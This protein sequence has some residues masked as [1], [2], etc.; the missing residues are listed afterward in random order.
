MLTAK[1]ASIRTK[2]LIRFKEDIYIVIK[3][4]YF[5]GD[6][7]IFNVYVPPNRV[8]KYVSQKVVELNGRIYKS[9][10]TVTESSVL[11]LSK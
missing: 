10:I 7:I 11:L 5:E 6:I 8:S 9:T 2:K 4:K 3:G 1:K